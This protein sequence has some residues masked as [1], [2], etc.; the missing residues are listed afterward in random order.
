MDILINT[1]FTL[2]GFLL[3]IIYSWW[4]NC[5]AEKKT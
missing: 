4:S 1:I 5:R 3:G 2:S